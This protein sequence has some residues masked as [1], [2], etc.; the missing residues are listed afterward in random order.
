MAGLL[1]KDQVAKREMLLDL[2]VFADMRSTPFFTRVKKSKQLTNTLFEWPADNYED[3]DT[4]PVVDGTDHSQYGNH[5]ENRGIIRN[6]I[7]NQRKGY[8]VSPLAENVSNVAGVPSEEAL[9]KKKLIEVMSRA[10]EAILCGDGEMAGDDGATGYKTRGLGKWIQATAQAT[11]AVPESHR[12]PTGSI[13]TTAAASLSEESDI[14]EILQSVYD[15]TGM[16]G[17]F[18]FL[19]GSVM[20]RALTTS[21]RITTG[22]TNTYYRPHVRAER[23]LGE[24]DHD[25][26]RRRLRP[27]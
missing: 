2:M 7:H 24:A 16:N 10:V 14:Q 13:R 21:T 12:P 11:N 8:I 27:A 18:V 22:N 15:A 1:E 17:N 26:L 5:A 4:A 20:R 6:Y 3:P 9:A 25:Q 19:T 23:Q